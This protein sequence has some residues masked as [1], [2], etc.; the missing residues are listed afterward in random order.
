MPLDAQYPAK[1]LSFMLEDAEVSV[2]LTQEHIAEQLLNNWAGTNISQ[3]VKLDSEW[4]E[5]ARE[6]DENLPRAATPDNLAYVIYTSGSTGQPKGVMVSHRGL[7]NYLEWCE[8]AYRLKQA[9]STVVHSP[10]GFDLTV[11]SLYTPLL[12][13][14]SMSL[15]DEEQGFEGLSE[16]LLAGPPH[17]LV[18]MTPAHLKLLNQIHADVDGERGNA[19][20]AGAGVGR[21]GTV[22]GGSAAMAGAVARDENNQ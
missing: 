13:G 6:T 15:L 16:T 12:V 4:P 21:R 2:L 20:G 18:K 11:T 8:S 14:Q 10:L 7:V 5:I 1:R 22:L 17:G 9:G 3:V 19:A